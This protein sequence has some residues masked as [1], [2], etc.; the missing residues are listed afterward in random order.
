MMCSRQK[1]SYQT[2]ASLQDVTNLPVWPFRLSA[3]PLLQCG[4]CGDIDED[5]GSRILACR[6]PLLLYG[7]AP[8]RP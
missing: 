5:E 1:I 4:L 2:K 8:L 7:R 3:G 6:E